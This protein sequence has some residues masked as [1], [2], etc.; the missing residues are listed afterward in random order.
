[1]FG[2]FIV[3]AIVRRPSVLKASSVPTS[4]NSRYSASE[5]AGRTTRCRFSM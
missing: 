3:T 2:T 1:M 5:R 4:G